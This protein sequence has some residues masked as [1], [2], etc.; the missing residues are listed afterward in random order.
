MAWAGISASGKRV[1]Q[2]LGEKETM[3]ASRYVLTLEKIGA[4]NLLKEISLVLFHDM[5]CHTAPNCLQL[6]V[7]RSGE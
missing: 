1:L 2:F 7:E 3:T 6:L 4:G 5:A